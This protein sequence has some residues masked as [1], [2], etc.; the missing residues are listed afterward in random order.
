MAG[1]Q[2][3][4]SAATHQQQ[5][6]RQVSTCGF[7]LGRLLM[8][9][10]L[11]LNTYSTAR[12]GSTACLTEVTAPVVGSTHRGSVISRL[13]GSTSTHQCTGELALGY[14]PYDAD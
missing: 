1:G 7:R 6:I 4:E 5:M 3:S 2:I 10:L 13:E 8:Y 11:S 12:Y 9:T 14:I